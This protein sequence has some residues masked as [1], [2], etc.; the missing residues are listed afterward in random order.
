[1]QEQTQVTCSQ[2]GQ[3]FNSQGE[4]DTHMRDAHGMTDTQAEAV[5]E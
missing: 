5:G 4:L 3:E 2:C 1:M